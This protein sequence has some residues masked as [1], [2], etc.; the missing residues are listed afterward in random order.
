MLV[1]KE[2][3]LSKILK[4]YSNEWIALSFDE[5][6]VISHGKSLPDVIKEA[7]ERGEPK[8]IVTRVPKDYGNY[9]LGF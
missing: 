4:K 9:V 1:L 7:K 5:K 3:N 8:P 2:E 6:K